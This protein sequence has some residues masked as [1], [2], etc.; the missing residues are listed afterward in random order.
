[1]VVVGV[2]RGA[3]HDDPAAVRHRPHHRM[4][5]RVHLGQGRDVPD[6][7]GVQHHG[8]RPSVVRGESGALQDRA[9]AGVRLPGRQVEQAAVEPGPAGRAAVQ[10]GWARQP[11]PAGQEAAGCGAGE[12]EVTVGHACLPGGRH[13]LTLE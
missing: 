2:E 10:L 11:E 1:M 8:G 5:G 13:V 12:A 9:D 6:A 7:G 4:Q 3:E